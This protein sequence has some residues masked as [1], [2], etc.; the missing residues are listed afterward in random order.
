MTPIALTVAGSD[1]SGGAGVQADLKAFSAF[2]VYGA[3]VITALTAQN[4]RGVQGIETVPADFVVAQLDSVFSDLDVAAAKTGMLA[5]AAIVVA[6]AGRLKTAP[7]LP[8][9][10]DPVM[11]A[12]SGDVLLEPG[13]V[14]ALT[15]ELFPLAALITPN[16]PEAARLLGAE[17]AADEEAAIAQA[18]AL[19]ALG[20]RAV[21]LKGGHGTGAAAVDVLYDGAKIERYALPRIDTRHTHGAGCTLSAA[22]AALLA[23]GTP[24]AEAV[25]RAKTFVWHALEAGRVLTV[26]K[27][28]GPADPLFAIRS[29]PP[30]A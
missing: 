25:G 24:L 6:L 20:P 15:R 2:G 22:I 26:G 9:V 8:L 5:S 3:S 7:P 13:A 1:S 28:A 12:S 29:K 11:V 18:R 14:E 19:H 4:T 21:L 10:V 23:L 17:E 16:L 30:P 27:G